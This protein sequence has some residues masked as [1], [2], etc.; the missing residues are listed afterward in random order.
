MRALC[1]QGGPSE[2]HGNAACGERPVPGKLSSWEETEDS[3]QYLRRVP[4]SSALSPDAPESPWA[5][6]SQPA[7]LWSLTSRESQ[8]PPHSPARRLLCGHRHGPGLAGALSA[9]CRDCSVQLSSVAG[10][11]S[12]RILP[13]PGPRPPPQPSQQIQ[14]LEP[15]LLQSE[16][17][18]LFQKAVL[19]TE[20]RACSCPPRA[21]PS[22]LSR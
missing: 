14:R 3:A 5:Q 10:R 8:E 21:S 13:G 6:G 1:P 2:S 11:S 9:R 22:H 20:Q 7:V 15:N 4:T 19:G 16:V 17:R 12:A 18:A